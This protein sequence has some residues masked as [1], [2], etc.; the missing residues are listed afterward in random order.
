MKHL[1]IKHDNGCISLTDGSD[2]FI[3]DK[4]YIHEV[5]DAISA[6]LPLN[7]RVDIEIEILIPDHP[8]LSL[9]K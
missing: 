9:V 7:G 1:I 3:I 4:D 6:V 8:S 2:N 5:L